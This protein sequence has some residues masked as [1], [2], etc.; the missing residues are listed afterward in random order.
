M[1]EVTQR[2]LLLSQLKEKKKE[3]FTE[4]AS[5]IHLGTGRWAVEFGFVESFTL[6]TEIGIDRND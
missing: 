5:Q 2:C 4:A 1:E 6:S 3:G